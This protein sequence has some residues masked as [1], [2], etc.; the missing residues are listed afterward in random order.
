MKLHDGGAVLI[1][2][3]FAIILA[4]LMAAERSDKV[5]KATEKAGK[6]IERQMDRL[7]R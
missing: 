3:L 6:Q 7:P 4:G 1:F 5:Q 2:G